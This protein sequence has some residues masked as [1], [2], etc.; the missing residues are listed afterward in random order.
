M[1]LKLSSCIFVLAFGF[2]LSSCSFDS[3]QVQLATPELKIEK[4]GKSSFTVS[5]NSVPD[6]H[7]YTYIFQN[8]MSVTTIDTLLTFTDLGVGIYTL[9]V[10]A[11]APANSAEYMDSQYA[12]LDIEIEGIDLIQ[13]AI[14]EISPLSAKALTAPVNNE[15]M[16]LSD[17]MPKSEFDQ[18]ESDEYIMEHHITYVTSV[19]EERGKSLTDM[20]TKGSDTYEYKNLQPCTE[21]VVFAFAINADGKCASRLFSRSFTTL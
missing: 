19:A 9:S 3:V 21:Y 5:W 8:K 10:K 14:F 20:A 7:S 12:F 4:K 11:N 15:I 13:I 2:A 17:I 18:I 16:Y 1:H 6:A